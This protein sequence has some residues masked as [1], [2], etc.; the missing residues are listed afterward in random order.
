PAFGDLESD[1]LAVTVPAA[2][3]GKGVCALPDVGDRV[4]VVFANLDLAWGVV[5][6]GVFGAGR[7][8]EPGAPQAQARSFT[9]RTARGHVVHLDDDADVLRLSDRTGSTVELGP[10]RVVLHA[11]VD[12]E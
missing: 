10:E 9:L 1:W 12:L 4:L 5:L 2:G 6:G 7:P 8:P 3:D 11:K